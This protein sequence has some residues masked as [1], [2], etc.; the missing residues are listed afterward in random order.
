MPETEKEYKKHYND[1]ASVGLR[2]LCN[3][4][5]L[6]R[7]NNCYN[8]KPEV[9]IENDNATILWYVTIR[10]DHMIENRKPDVV[11][12]K[13]ESKRYWNIT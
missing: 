6:D 5:G 10:C 12:V 13:K 3:K 4:N 9:V 2:N 8:H 7:G 11:L 1:I